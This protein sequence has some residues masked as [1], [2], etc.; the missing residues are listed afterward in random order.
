MNKAQQV[1]ELAEQYRDRILDIFRHLHQHPETST[2]EYRTTEY[3]RS[4]LEDLGIE[5]IDSGV[6]TGTIGL[7]R[8]AEDGPCVALR[9][10]IDALPVKEQ[11]TCPFPSL[12]EGAMHACGHDTH[13]TSL[14]GSAILLAHMRDQI[15]GS[16]KFIFQPAEEKNIGAISMIANGALENPEVKACF[17]L[18]NSPEVPTGSVAVLPGPIM[19]GLNTIDIEILGK[20]GH[21]GIPQRNTDPVVAAAAV[22][23]SLQTIV[24]RN[25]APTNA[26]VISICSVHTDNPMISNV[27]PDKVSME[28]T[29]RYYSYEDK[30]M[31]DR[32]IREVVEGIGAAYNCETRYW[33]SEDLPITSNTPIDGQISLYETALKTVRDIGATA[34]CPDPSGG[35]DDFAHY[36]LGAGDKPGVPSFFYWLGVRNE[37]KDCVYSWHSP[38]YQADTDALPIGAKLLAMSAFNALDLFG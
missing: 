31:I 38:Q 23:Q 29:V 4:V 35:G 32:R 17:S 21:G 28:G 15:R 36:A 5:L 9:A 18:H 24:S 26:A 22:I 13:I 7:L 25:V 14:L 30:A 34:V 10:D 11:S 16:V 20:G 12:N 27:I 19:A 8:G 2:H 6:E 3:I 33:T 37:Q 1:N